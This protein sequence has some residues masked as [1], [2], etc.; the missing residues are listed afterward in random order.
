[1]LSFCLR[2]L[3]MMATGDFGNSWRKLKVFISTLCIELA[4][5]I[6]TFLCV[7]FVTWRLVSLSCVCALICIPCSSKNGF[8]NQLIKNEMTLSWFWYRSALWWSNLSDCFMSAGCLWLI[9][10]SSTLMVQLW[11]NCFFRLD[12]VFIQIW[13]TGLLAMSYAIF[14]QWE[15]KGESMFIVYRVLGRWLRNPASSFTWCYKCALCWS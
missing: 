15:V 6:D 5:S 9:W 7:Y 10:T 12:L 11:T 14:C 3:S 13:P 1:M 8:F 4:W 2:S